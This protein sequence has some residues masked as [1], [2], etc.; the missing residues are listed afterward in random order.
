MTTRFVETEQGREMLMRYVAERALPFSASIVKG[1]RRSDAQNRLQRRW[2]GE[3]AEQLPDQSAEEWR[4]YCK[5]HFGVPIMRAE[6]DAF[7][8]QYDEIIR[9]LPYEHKLAL[10]MVPLD[11]PVTRIMNVRQKTAY[12]DAIHHH[13]SAQGVILTDPEN[14]R[15]RSE[16]VAA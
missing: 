15:Y 6:S 10:M 8:T 3:I 4:G 9:P 12:L 16:A 14:L 2:V 5:L 7:Q 13:F 1:K 11:L